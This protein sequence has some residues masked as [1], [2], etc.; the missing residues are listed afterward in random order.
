MWKAN[1]L[2]RSEVE[3]L[4]ASGANAAANEENRRNEDAPRA[5]SA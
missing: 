2:Y 3:K 4:K 1:N 5:T